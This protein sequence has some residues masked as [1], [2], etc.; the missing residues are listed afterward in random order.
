MPPFAF[1]KAVTCTPEGRVPQ[2]TGKPGGK[3]PPHRRAQR[4][5]LR[6]TT[7][8]HA[9]TARRLQPSQPVLL[10]PLLAV[11][12][13]FDNSRNA[14][15]R[16]KQ[17][18]PPTQNSDDEKQAKYGKNNKCHDAKIRKNNYKKP[19]MCYGLASSLFYFANENCFR[20]LFL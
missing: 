19:K 6:T 16:N 4:H 8:C 18:R 10:F 17:Q 9:A 11:L 15:K 3:T 2:G 20:M 1:Q 7:G 13:V 5:I 14:V 12:I